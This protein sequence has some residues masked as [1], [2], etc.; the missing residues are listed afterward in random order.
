MSLVSV[1]IPYYRNKKYIKGCINSILGQS[2]QKFEIILVYDDTNLSDLAYIK[3]ISKLDNRIILLI[4]KKNIG[5]GLSRNV[6]IN[7]ARGKYI[8][9][10]DS[11][12]LWTKNKLKIQ[13]NFMRMNEHRAS[14]TSYKIIDSKNKTIGSGKAR[15]FI[16]VEDLLKSCDIGLSTVLLEKKILLE[17]GMF[18]KT[19]TKEDFILWLKIL[20]KKIKIAS[21]DQNLTAWRKTK[22]SLS[23]SIIQ[24][25]YDGFIVYN[26]HMKFNYIKSIYYLIIL[27]LN[28]LKK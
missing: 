18:H 4:N 19:K 26:K 3:K 10:I 20:S 13:L 8:A 2:H 16:K 21:L 6:G 5:A 24:K 7:K 17:T 11:D 25:L 28:S 15:N 23:S 1:I 27:S 14:H 22:G 12:D 9:F